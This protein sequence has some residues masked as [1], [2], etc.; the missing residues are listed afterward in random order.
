MQVDLLTPARR[1]HG[2]ISLHM[3]TDRYPC[4][5]RI[6]AALHSRATD[7]PRAVPRTF[8]APA[9]CGRVEGAVDIGLGEHALPVFRLRSNRDAKIVGRLDASTDKVLEF[10]LERVGLDHVRVAVATAAGSQLLDAQEEIAHDMAQAIQRNMR[11]SAERT[12]RRGRTEAWHRRRNS[13][14]G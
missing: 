2:I 4:S 13:R 10:Q 11:D 14:K 6:I 12:P 1:R 7:T 3:G 8:R 5:A 9:R